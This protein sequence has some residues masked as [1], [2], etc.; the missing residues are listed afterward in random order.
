MPTP[1]IETIALARRRYAEG[2]AVAAILDETGL[3]LGTL[4]AC[5]DGAIDCGAE[6]LPPLPRRRA[7]TAK[8]RGMPQVDR[9]S[10]VRR[11][12]SSAERQVRDIER[13]LALDRQEP[14]EG[15]RNARVLSVLVRTMRELTAFDAD[16]GE[17]TDMNAGDDNFPRDIDEL[18]RELARRI[19]A[20]RAD[21]LAASCGGSAPG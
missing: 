4:Y 9:V 3:S 14:D 15:E 13:R 19:S 5:L 11:L 16:N 17:T 2:V 10:L 21:H 7:T 12:W 8:R 18:R 6:R 1:A 20:I